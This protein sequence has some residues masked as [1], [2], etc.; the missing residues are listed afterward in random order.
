MKYKISEVDI[1][2]LYMVRITDKWSYPSGPTI[3]LCDIH[4]HDLH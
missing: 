3:T 1:V 4:M 2:V